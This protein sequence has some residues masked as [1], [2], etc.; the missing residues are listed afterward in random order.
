MIKIGDRISHLRKQK[1]W[2]QGDLAKAVKASRE[3]IGKYERNEAVPSVEMAKKIADVFDVTLDYLVDEKT[4]PSFDK[5]T[6][7]RLQEI[8]LLNEDD[9]KHLFAIMDAYLRDAN[10]RRAYS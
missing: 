4:N 1:G 6:V 9:K 2:S 10:T 8:E 7:K 5:S 3:A